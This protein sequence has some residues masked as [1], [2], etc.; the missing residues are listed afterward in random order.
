MNKRF[1]S[2]VAAIIITVVGFLWLTKPSSD[3]ASSSAVSNHT[4]GEGSKNVT[5]IEYGDF[6]CPA[7]AQYYPALKE[8]KEKY[9]ADI[10]FQ[11]RNFPLDSIHQ[12][13]RASA[14]AAEAAN[15]QGK[16]WEMHDMLYENQN[17]WANV[18]DPLS[19]FETF[20]MQ[21]GIKD[22]EKFRTD[23]KSGV[24]NDIINAD[25]REAQKIGST[26]TPTFVLEGAKIDNPDPTI[27]AFSKLIDEAIAKKNQQ[28]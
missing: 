8:V 21:I 28:Q 10:T 20:A 23:Y 11:F 16:F 4:F 5:L 25:V 27:E 13:A 7:C 24:V 22:V 1:L 9:K 18:N 6:Q 17:S 2:I 3:T 19:F 15:I 12:N 14:R 26:S